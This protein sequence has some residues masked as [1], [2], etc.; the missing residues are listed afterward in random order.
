MQTN[1]SCD[2]T[3]QMEVLVVLYRSTCTWSL[4]ARLFLLCSSSSHSHSLTLNKVHSCHQPLQESLTMS[5]ASSS[6]SSICMLLVLPTVLLP[7]DESLSLF[8][9]SHIPSPSSNR[10]CAHALLTIANSA[11]C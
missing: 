4:C 5:A 2:S 6:F 8:V 3:S 11:L 7:N 1:K 9:F 10:D